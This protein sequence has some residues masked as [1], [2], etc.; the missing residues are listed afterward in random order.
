MEENAASSNSYRLRCSI[1][2][3]EMDVRGL[4]AAVFPEGGFVSVSRDRTGRI[5]V[6]NSSPDNGFTEMQCMSGHS[7]FVSC[8]CIIAPS[9]IYPRGLIATGG[10]DN[11]I[12]VFTLDQPKPLYTLVGHKNTVCTLS[13]GK[14]GTLLSGSW[15]TTAKVWLS[16]K[17]MM[18]LQGHSAAVW[19]VAMLPEQGLM[20][21]GSA[22]RTIKLWKAGRCEK[23]FTGHEDCV[24]GLVVISSTE[25]FSCSNDT[26][27]RR[28]L[29]SG[30]CAQVYYGHTN[31]IYSI[32][33]FP[34]SQDFVSTGE[35]RTVR[36]WRSGECTQ[37]IRLPAQSVW[38]C[39]ILPNGDIAVGASDGIIRVFTE[40]EDRMASAEDLQAFEDELSK[41]TIDPKTGDLGDI[42]LEELPGREHLDEPGN[43]DGQTRLIKDG[44]KVEAY[45]WS[46]S[47]SRWVKIGDVV[48][49]SNQQTSKSVMYEGKEYDYVFTI[50][51]NEGGPSM[52]LPYNVSED[53]WLTAHNFLQKNDLSP[54]FLDQVANFIIENT[55]GHVVGP[56]QP[57]SGDPFTG[58]ARY[59]PG[60]SDGGPNFGGDPFTGS[61]RYIPGSGT[62]AVAPEGVADPFTGGGAYSSA[63]LQQNITN[64][65]FPKTDGVTFEQANISQIVGKLK[66]LNAGAPQEHKLSEDFLESLERLLVSVS[67]PN[68]C[69]PTIQQISLLWKAS[70][71]PE[72]IVFPVLDI[73]RLAVRHPQ[74]NE[75]LCGEAEG[76]QLCNHL[77]SLMRPE[78][79]AANQM[80]ALR[81]LCNCFGSGHGRAL[82]LA[83][84]EA[85]LSRAADLAAVCNKNIHIALATLVLNYAG[86]LHTQPDLEAK[87]QC[88][89]VASRALET[90]QDKEAVFRLLVALGTT[91]AA[92]Q[93]ARDLARS[94]G[95]N[96]QI[97][98]YSSVSD[99]S[100]LGECCR[101]VLQELQ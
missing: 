93:T 58:G 56:T 14:F 97:S 63:A 61:G 32:A 4:A 48:G 72:D 31:Y 52:K 89:S 27:I 62:D 15:D 68:E 12:C 2:G 34:N 30:E 77:L 26:S 71:W 59:I 92:D 46:V 82:L 76:V 25:F 22:D 51:V 67:S 79:R 9:E 96:V 33:I 35:D 70:H 54:M 65:Y 21:S 74:V 57:A 73:L 8:V 78:G 6:P 16:E 5:W 47:D 19:A 84:R 39:C 24:R 100:K 91:V 41:A 49:G 29:V 55:K 99:P 3:H 66:E 80:L 36:I 40:A 60:S 88:L 53:P 94:L 17:C 87:A 101:L 7:N 81:I 10:N 98:Q 38:C 45:Q 1:P 44:Q 86:C 64:I 37:T 50:D 23:T 11:N 83:Q 85:V 69:P 18:T 20:L 43:R 42:K 95:V 13:S 90:I 75:S 28:W